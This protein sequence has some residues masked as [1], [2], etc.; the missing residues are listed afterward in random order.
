M[1]MEVVIL[2]G[3]VSLE[4][5]FWFSVFLDVAARDA[6]DFHCVPGQ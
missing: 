4:A 6:N 1:A 3:A 5:G 2:M